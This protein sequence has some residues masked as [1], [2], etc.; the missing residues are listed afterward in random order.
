MLINIL[1]KNKIDPKITKII[2]NLIKLRRLFF[3]N[4]NNYDNSRFSNIGLP[5]SSI[6]TPILFNILLYDLHK[7]V[8]NYIQRISFAD[9]VCFFSQMI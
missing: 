3:K 8:P 1:I 2:H 6:L 9:D 4:F 7:N 5:Q